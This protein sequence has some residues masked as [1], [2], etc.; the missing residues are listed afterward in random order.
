MCAEDYDENVGNNLVLSDEGLNFIAGYEGFS[1]Y[2]YEDQGGLPTI[3]YGH[4]IQPGETFYEPMTEEEGLEL[5]RTDVIR[6]EE[7]VNE[8]VTVDLEQ[9]EFD[10]CVSLAFNIGDNAFRN[11][12]AVRE[13]NS[14]DLEAMEREWREWRLVNGQVSQGLVNR[15]S[16]ELEM[17]FEGDYNRN[18]F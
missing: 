11:S 17:F 15:R 10:A 13:L 3:G 2:I 1:A 7:A 8:A 18:H 14:V 4:L 6:F 16:D 12:N 9:H 5:L